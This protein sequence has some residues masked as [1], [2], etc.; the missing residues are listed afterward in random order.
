MFFAWGRRRSLAVA[1][2]LLAAAWRDR[3]PAA[4]RRGCAGPSVRLQRRSSAGRARAA[5]ARA[6]TTRLAPLC[7]CACGREGCQ[8]G[9]TPEGCGH[10]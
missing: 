10:L 9:A 7:R 1:S 2:R 5:A 8:R 3:S 6:A 4:R